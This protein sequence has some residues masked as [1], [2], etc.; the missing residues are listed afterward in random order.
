MAYGEQYMMHEYCTLFYDFKQ[1]IGDMDI[2]NP[3]RILRKYLEDCSIDVER[4][5]MDLTLRDINIKSTYYF[6]K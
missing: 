2:I 1:L 3:E 6:G 4:P 5:E